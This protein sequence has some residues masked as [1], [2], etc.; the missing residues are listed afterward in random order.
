MVY[1][2]NTCTAAIRTLP[3]LQ[4]SDVN[5]EDLDTSQE[6][7][8]ADSFR[9][10]C[11]SRPITPQHCAEKAPFEDDPLELNTKKYG[12]YSYR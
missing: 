1:F 9:Y 10:F 12:Q 5:P 3:L 8:F 4:F 11:M 7:H 2:F 6:D